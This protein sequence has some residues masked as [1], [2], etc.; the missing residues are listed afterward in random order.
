MDYNVYDEAVKVLFSGGNPYLH[1]ITM[2]GPFNYPPTVFLFISFLQ[3]RLIFDILSALAFFISIFLLTNKKF[4]VSFFLFF[5][6]LLI[7]FPYKFNVGMGQINNFILLFVV[8]AYYY[9]PFFLAYAISIKL[10]P[11]I[12]LFYYFIKKDYKKIII[13]LTLC[14]ILYAM[15]LIIVP[16]DFQKIYFLDVFWRAFGTGGKEVYYNQSLAGLLARSNTSFLFYPLTI[17][18]LFVTYIKGKKL[19]RERVFSAV[20]CLMLILNPIAWQHQFVFAII[21]L[22]LLFNLNKKLVLAVFFLLAWNFKQPDL[23]PKELSSH[24][25]YGVFILWMLAIFGG[26]STKLIG[27]I[28]TV[29]IIG[30]YLRFLICRGSFCF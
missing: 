18:L 15:S 3:N 26:K 29:G 1:L 13:V 22:I 12:F 6:S 20:T 27:I 30:V 9:N 23:V 4:F 24:Q 25:F 11:I 7:F 8:L 21:P 16:F 5:V 10:T 2:P 17:L 28:G 14:L 19:K